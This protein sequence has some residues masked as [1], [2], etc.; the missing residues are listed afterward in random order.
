MVRV[1]RAT[2][3]DPGEAERYLRVGHALHGTARDLAALAEPKYGNA[4]AIVA[5]HAV[6]AHADALT[7][8]FGGVK[9]AEGDHTR[10]VPLLQ[11]VLRQRIGAAEVRRVRSVLT[12]KSDVSYSGRYYTLDAALSILRDADEFIEWARTMYEQ[13]PRPF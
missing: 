1:G 11:H 13:R 6:I 7:V 9:S 10:V 3:V 5:V 12:A 8:A 2:S 4:L